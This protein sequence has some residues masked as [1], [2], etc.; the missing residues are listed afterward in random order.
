[1]TYTITEAVND[2][3]KTIE[4][5]ERYNREHRLPMNRE[6]W[7]AY[8]KMEHLTDEQMWRYFKLAE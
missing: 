3:Q 1:M 2:C 6:W 4:E 8:K 7:D 5:L